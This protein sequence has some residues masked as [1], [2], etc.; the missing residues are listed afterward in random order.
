MSGDQSS[1]FTISEQKLSWF[2][3]SSYHTHTFFKPL[4]L[5]TSVYQEDK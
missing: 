1:Q 5:Y 2:A 3:E 4:L